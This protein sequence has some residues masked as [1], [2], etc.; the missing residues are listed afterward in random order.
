MGAK[1]APSSVK[2]SGEEGG[3][4]NLYVADVLGTLI[5]A[6]EGLA[7]GMKRPV[8]QTLLLNNRECSIVSM[9]SGE[10]SA[11]MIGLM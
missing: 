5:G 1:E 4:V 2:S 8:G 3:I 6:L 10:L 11:I 7:R 9:R